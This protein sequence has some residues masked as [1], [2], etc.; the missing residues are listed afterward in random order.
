M[1]AGLAPDDKRLLSKKPLW[2]YRFHDLRST[3][4]TEWLRLQQRT[5]NAPYDFYFSELKQLLGHELNTDTQK[6]IDFVN[7][8]DIFSAAAANRNAEAAQALK[9]YEH[10]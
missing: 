4:A 7:H 3:F 8:F 2:Y 9:G 6:Y 10:G 1:R 5:R